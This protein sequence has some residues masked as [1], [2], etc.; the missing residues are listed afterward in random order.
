MKNIL[1]IL[2]LSTMLYSCKNNSNNSDVKFIQKLG[3]IDN[4]KYEQ[5]KFESP[6]RCACRASSKELWLDKPKTKRLANSNRA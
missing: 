6:S 4:Q 5:L 1:S 3:L 2:L